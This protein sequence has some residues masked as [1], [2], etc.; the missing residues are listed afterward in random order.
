MSEKSSTRNAANRAC[1]GAGNAIYGLGLIGALIFFWQ[2][3][4]SFG[5]FLVAILKALVWPA[6]LVYEVFQHLLG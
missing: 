5:G 6:F 3:A 1:T 2:Q 4:E